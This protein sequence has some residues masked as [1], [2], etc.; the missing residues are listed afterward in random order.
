[1]VVDFQQRFAFNDDHD[2]KGCAYYEK[3]LNV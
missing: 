3:W 1:M 2:I